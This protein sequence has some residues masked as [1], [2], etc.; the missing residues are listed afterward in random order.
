M[1]PFLA[2][3]EDK[4]STAELVP[5]RVVLMRGGTSKG[6][7][8]NESDLPADTARREQF[9]LAA[10]GSPDPRQI[11]GIGGADPLTSKV[12][13]I[14]PGRRH[15]AD[16]TY[17]FAQVGIDE[18]FVALNANCGNLSAAVAVYAI[19]AGFV[20]PVEPETTVRIFNTNARQML[21][22]HVPVRNGR[23]AVRGSLAIAGVPGFG[24]EI[25]MDYSRTLGAMTGKLL[26]TGN[27]KDRLYVPELGG[28]VEV[29]IVDVAKATCFFRAEEI[30]I[31]GTEGPEEISAEAMARFWAIRKAAAIACGFGPDSRHPL[32]VAVSPATSYINYLTKETVVAEDMSFVARRI[33]GPPPRM[34]KAFASTGAVCTGAAANLTG[35]I[36]ADVTSPIVDGLV[37]IGHPTGVFPVR[38][39]LNEQGEVLEAS[40][41][42]TARRLF[43]GVL[44]THRVSKFVPHSG[45]TNDEL[46][47]SDGQ[48]G[49]LG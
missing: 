19:E 30:G 17:T 27:L 9:I 47:S 1:T 29:S 21:V 35:T 32:P 49:D 48:I 45:S 42:R 33:V 5:T 39:R 40:Y 8:F 22:A 13:I 24:A 16:V 20:L 4:D 6:V 26:P 12:C 15:D 31:T 3:I 34:H 23:P 44:Y 25:R 2:G 38:V 43:D 11:D 28:S 46:K 37:K 14:G 10:M 18:A 41:S 7:F 36:V